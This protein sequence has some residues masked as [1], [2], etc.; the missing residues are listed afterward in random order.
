MKVYKL[1]NQTINAAAVERV[2]H[3]DGSIMVCLYSGA[4][5]WLDGYSADRFLASFEGDVEEMVEL[6]RPP[7]F[8]FVILDDIYSLGDDEIPGF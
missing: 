1:G 5:L 8:D 2:A 7:D 3:C 6:D 4:K